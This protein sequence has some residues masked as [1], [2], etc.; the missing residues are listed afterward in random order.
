MAISILICSGILPQYNP[1]P[2]GYTRM[3]AGVPAEGCHELTEYKS[4]SVQVV[5]LGPF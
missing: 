4:T 1:H 3:S 2:K 5:H